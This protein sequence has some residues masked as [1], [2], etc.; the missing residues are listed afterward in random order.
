MTTV[1]KGFRTSTPAWVASA[2]GT[3]PK[4]ATSAAMS[5]ARTPSRDPW[6]IAVTTFEKHMI[7][8]GR[9]RNHEDSSLVESH[10]DY[11]SI[12]GPKHQHFLARRG[13]AI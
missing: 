13:R 8:A 5:T 1:A 12:V 3:N 2:I 6:T 7:F 11:G 9:C 10:L 4:D